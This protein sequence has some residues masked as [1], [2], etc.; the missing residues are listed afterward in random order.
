MSDQDAR[1]LAIVSEYSRYAAAAG[2]IPMPLLDMA[3]VSGI[4]IAMLSK[5]ADAYEVPFSKDRVSPI[6]ASLIG[7]V[8]SAG[9]GHGVAKQ[10]IKGLPVIG[11]VVGAIWMPAMAGAVTW[12]VGK[13]FVQHFAMGGTLFDFE[14]D[15]WRSRVREEVTSR[16]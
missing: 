7:G 9:L 2:F 4:Q 16:L 13:V 10:F 11:P 3:A 15:K 12:A 6:L 14:P 5:I 1:A 8:T